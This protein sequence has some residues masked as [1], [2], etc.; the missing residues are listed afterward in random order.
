MILV[1][2]VLDAVLRLV[3]YG[4]STS[5]ASAD[6]DLARGGSEMYGSKSV[7]AFAP[8]VA[9]LLEALDRGSER[10]VAEKLRTTHL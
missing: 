1:A 4:G 6:G 10:Q 2:D 7:S 9:K 8:T 5:G 3:G